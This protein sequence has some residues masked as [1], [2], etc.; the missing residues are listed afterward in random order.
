MS[1]NRAFET[2][3]IDKKGNSPFGKKSVKDDAPFD[4]VEEDDSQNY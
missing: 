3:T 4:E 2:Q 1:T